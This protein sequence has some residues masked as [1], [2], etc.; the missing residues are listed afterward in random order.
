MGD[1]KPSCSFPRRYFAPYP[2]FFQAAI[3]RGLFSGLTPK[4]DALQLC[5]RDALGLPLA[6]ELPFRLGHIAEKLQD[7]V[8]DQRSGQILILPRVQQRHIQ[9]HNGG[10]FFLGNDAPLFQD[11]I[12]IASQAVDALDNKGVA[13]FYFAYQ[14]LVILP[15]K[16][17]SRLLVQKNVPVC[18]NNFFILSPFYIP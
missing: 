3:F 2:Q 18:N 9:H 16:V 4:P 12:I 7:D 13:A 8:R 5:R 10:A 15:L 14:F 17:F 11:F 6:D 1:T